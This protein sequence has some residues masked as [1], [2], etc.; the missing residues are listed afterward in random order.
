[1]RSDALNN[2]ILCCVILLVIM[3]LLSLPRFLY[4]WI[5]VMDTLNALALENLGGNIHNSVEEGY[6]DSDF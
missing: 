1:M 2:V 6:V 4:I 5:T 3:Q